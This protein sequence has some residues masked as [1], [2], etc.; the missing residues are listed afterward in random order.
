M[1]T[2][3][4]DD[5][6]HR[7]L[8][9]GKKVVKLLLDLQNEKYKD[10][11]MSD[12]SVIIER[13]KLSYSYVKAAHYWLEDLKSMFETDEYIICKKDKYVFI[14]HQD[15]CMSFCGITVDNC[16][17]VCTRDYKWINDQILMLKNAFQEVTMETGDKIGSGN[18]AKDEPR[19]ETSCYYTTKT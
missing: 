2:P 14:K 11:V 13:D 15:T 16:P 12:G 1:D 8:K 17:F 19:A 3:I 5:V 10:Y 9:L 4:S 7:W 6:K 18:A